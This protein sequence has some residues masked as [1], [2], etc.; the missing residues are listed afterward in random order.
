MSV[1]SNTN[2]VRALNRGDF[3]AAVALGS[4]GSSARILK[5]FVQVQ[6]NN[7]TRNAW[8]YGS[9]A[10]VHVPAS[11]VAVEAIS[12]STNDSSS[13]TGARTIRVDGL[14]TGG[15]F[16]SVTVTMNGTSAV[17]ITPPLS[18]VLSVEVLTAGSGTLN[19]GNISIRTV[20]GASVMGYV[21][22]AFGQMDSLCYS[23]PAGRQAFVL[24]A[25]FEP[26]FAD[27]SYTDASTAVSTEASQMIFYRRNAS[28]V[29]VMESRLACRRVPNSRDFGFGFHLAAGEDLDVSLQTTGAN[30]PY[31]GFLNILELPA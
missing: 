27:V 6:I 8:G 13:G 11:P 28:G 24:S 10:N 17:A 26:A 5:R 1:K 20:S 4:A 31:T 30:R 3:A 22:A 23:V 19:A 25:G 9:T 14:T 21:Q 16:V 15:E 18:R 29:Y 7:Q 2:L 12:S